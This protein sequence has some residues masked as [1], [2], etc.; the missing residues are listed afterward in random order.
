MRKRNPRNGSLATRLTI[1]MTTLVI[2]AITSV[3]LLSL[4]RQ[5]ETF[6]AELQQQAEILL[7]TLVV[8]S[9]DPLYFLDVSFLKELMGELGEDKVLVAGYVYDKDG[10]ILADAHHAG[11]LTY[12][13]KPNAFGQQLVKS[14]HIQF[15][16]QQDRLIAGKAVFLGHQTVGAVSVGL[17]TEPLKAKMNAVRDQGIAVALAAALIGTF[18]SLLLS[19]SITEPLKQMT[20]AT[21][22]LAGGDLSQT[23][24]INTNDELAV[25]ADSFNS[26]TF[27]LRNLI[28]GIQHRAEQ[29]RQSEGKNRALLN[30]IP[31]LILLLNQQGIVLDCKYK[32]L[33]ENSLPANFEEIIG[34]TVQEVFAPSIAELLLYYTHNALIND[35]LQIF[36]YEQLLK[37]KKHYYEARIMVSGRKEVLTL[38]RDITKNKLAQAQ[39]QQAKEAAEAANHAK[40]AF[41][42]S[43]SHEL[44]TPLNGI[45][46]LSQLLLED[47]EEEGYIEFIDDLKQIH[48]SGLHLLSLIED[49]LD[50]SKIEAGKMTLYPE[51]FDLPVLINEV[52]NTIQPLIKK[53]IIL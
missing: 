50:I 20:G 22:R 11:I 44:R 3:T 37:D 49:I 33:K 17:S 2:F 39:W 23:I 4:R 13:V 41:L 52:K 1:A 19:R 5:Q 31:D 48:Q 21:Q 42:A 46:G 25:L 24:S 7:N 29:L 8:T 38:I 16:W 51:T 14:P 27:Q 32:S 45:L 18:I 26:M 53:I 40:S 34:K 30:A 6:Q 28:D 47:A 9:A 15:F 36:E 35:E 12:G 10:R 43:M